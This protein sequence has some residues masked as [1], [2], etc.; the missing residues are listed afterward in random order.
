VLVASWV[1][2]HA[3]ADGFTRFIRRDPLGVALTALTWNARPYVRTPEVAARALLS[4][5]AVVTP[6]AL[7]EQLGSESA[8]VMVQHNAPFWQPPARV[9][10][11][12]LWL[13]GEQDAVVSEAA[14]R[15]S[16]AYYGADYAVIPGAAHNLM[17]EASYRSTAER[18][19][20]W[21]EARG[22]A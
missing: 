6:D 22:V 16:A 2:H 12:L 17:M 13:A 9:A 1:S 21:L 14:E 8:M 19:H 18:I 4:E 15:A 7:Y 11:P 5:N 10:T 20:A 3:M